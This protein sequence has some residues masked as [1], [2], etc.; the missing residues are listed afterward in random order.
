MTRPVRFA[1]NAASRLAA[2]LTAIATTCT[3]TPGDGAKFPALSA[4]QYFMATL[5]KADGTK[6]VVRVTARATDT[7][8]IV[9]AAE[10]VA[11]VQ[12]AAV[13]SAGDRIELRMTADSLASEFD[14]LDL[15]AIVRV[16]NRATNYTV[17]PA[18]LN[19][20]F[21]VDTSAGARTISLPA[22]SSL[23]EEFKLMVAK[24]TNDANVVTVAANG[25]DTINGLSTLSLTQQ[26]A[27]AWLIADRS[28]N[29]WTAI[30][31]GSSAGNW[32]IDAFT[33]AGNSGPFNLSGNPGSKNNTMVWVGGVYQ[34]KSTYTLVGTALTLGGNVPV[35]VGVE[36][37][38]AAP[39]AFGVPNDGS[40]TTQKLGD[41]SVTTPKLLDRAVTAAKMFSAT[42]ARLWGRISAGSGDVEQLT[43]LQ[44]KEIVAPHRGHIAGLTLSTPGASS[45]MTVSAGEAADSAATAIMMLTGAIS[46]TTA[47]WAVGTGNGGLDTGTIANNTWY[48][49]YLIRR[50][51]TGVVDVLFSLSATAPTLPA[52]YTQFRRIGAG[53]T[54]ASAQWLRFFQDGDLFQWETPT[55]DVDVT[56]PGTAAVTRTLIV[57][58]GV[59]VAAQFQY[60]AYDP[61][62][63]NQVVAYFSDLQTVDGVPSVTAAPLASSVS[64]GA[65]P[66]GGFGRIEVMTNTSGQIRSR[67]T[68]AV[69]VSAVLKIS[70]VAWRDSRGRDA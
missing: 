18:D 15:S 19:T 36:V 16:L 49:F 37:A 46:K 35:G 66:I 8:T 70:T 58:T 3:V 27:G 34:E 50:P 53:R 54:N 2:N 44:A 43:G 24:V 4:G 6:E 38:W 23:G 28:T 60:G 7:F 1:N 14:R 68:G 61:T 12:A 20:L 13:F 30:N 64:Q 65:S 5:V 51:D 57:P 41:G 10:A 21:R 33:G 47:A 22:I 63:G 52:N 17:L 48:H 26:W 42:T 69:A 55:L 39:I 29:T 31:S 25:S 11:G 45:T 67:L 59:R 9:R 62:N 32:V 40:V 56:N